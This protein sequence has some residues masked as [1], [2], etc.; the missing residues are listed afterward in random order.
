MV[1][2]SDDTAMTSPVSTRANAAASHGQR[3]APASASPYLADPAMFHDACG[4][5]FIA[6]ID[7]V[8]SHRVVDL[9]VH[10]VSALTHRGAVNADPLTGDG[11][12]VTIQIPFELLREDCER[13][14]TPVESGDDLAVAMVFLPHD[15]AKRPAAREELEQEVRATGVDAIGWRNVPH[16]PAQLGPQAL[17]SLPGIEQLL[18]RRPHDQQGPAFERSLYLARRRAERRFREQELDCYVVSMSARTVVYKGLMIAPRLADFYPDLADERTVSALALF[19]Q[20]FATNTLPSW[21]LA[22]PF[23]MTAHNGEFNTLLGNRTWMA[24]REPELASPVWGD[25]ID[26]LKPVIQPI[27]SDTASFDEAI[28]LLAMSGRDLLHATMMMIPQAWEN[29]P[30]L[31]PQLRAFYEYHACLSE[32]WDG[33]AAVALTNGVQV[34]AIMDRNGLRPA[35]YQVTR[36]GLVV[37]GSEVG[38]IEFEP[39]EVIESGRIGPGEMIA[40]DTSRRV[41]LHNDEIKT[42]IAGRRPYGDWVRRNLLHLNTDDRNGSN[43]HRS[44]EL[45]H[46]LLTLQQLHG[47]THEEIEY[48]VKPMAEDGKEPVGSMGDDTPLSALQDEPRLLYTYFKQK[49]AQVT[50]PA[51]DSVREEIVMSLDTYLGRRR[52]MLESTPEAARLLHLT[53][54]LIHDDELTA[55]RRMQNDDIKVSTLHARFK[56]DEGPTALEQALDDLCTA[57][58]MAA[59]EGYSVIVISDRL[60]D[61][62]WAPVPML[63]A[64]STVHHHLVR[65][66]R[67]MKTSLVA[68]TG[69]AR[70][71]HHFA[72]LIGFGASAVNPYLAFATLSG[73]HAEGEFDDKPLEHVMESYARA[74]DT[75]ILKIMSKMGISAVSSYHGAQIFEALGIGPEVVDRC[76]TGTTSRIGGIGFEEM[77]SDVYERH[78]LSFPETEK[79]AHGGWYK[80]RRD[81][82]YH[83]YSPAMW[84]AL[85]KVAQTGHAVAN[86]AGDEAYREYL[87]VLE[88]A[89]VGTLRDLLRLKSDRDPID[90]SEVEPVEQI[91]ARFVT[92]AMS[93]GA[94]S[95][96]AHED[97]AR[98]MNVL[99]GRSN[100]GEGGEDPRRYSPD[101]DKRDANSKIKQVASGRFGVTPAYLAAAQEFEIKISQGSKP[102][103]GGQ[104]PGIKVNPYIAQLRHVMPGTPLIS[105]PPHHDIYS[106]EDIAQLIYDLK[107]VNPRAKVCVKLV[108]SEG[109]GVIAAGVA[110][111][112]ADIIQISGAEGGTGASPLSSIKYAGS[113]WEI[114]LAE[115]QQALVMNS[116]RGRVT[117]RA[118]GGYRSGRDVIVAAMLGAEQYGF[119]TAA[120]IAVGC[121]MARQCH[122]NTCPVG[123]A[124]QREDLREKYF[125]TPEMLITFLTHVAKQVRQTLADLG[126]RSIEE[127]IGRADL[128]E[129]VEPE[130]AHRWHRIDLSRVIAPVDPEGREPHRSMQPRN[131]RGDWKRLDDEILKE[132]LDNIDSR[133]QVS[134]S[135]PVKNTNRAVGTRVAG[136]IAERYGDTGLPYGTIDLTFTGSAG[137]SFGAFLSRGMRLHLSGEANDYV[138]KGM[139][140]GEITIR[141]HPEAGFKGNGGVLVGNTVLYGATGGNLFVAGAAGERFAVRNSGARA[142]VE[143]IGDHGCEYMTDGV[144]VILGDTGRNFGAGMSNGVAFVLDERGDFRSRVNQEL[145]GL[146]QVTN[147]EDIELLEALIRRH[148][149]VTDSPRAREI[150]RN[151]RLMLP[152]FWK[153]APKFAITEDGAQT[154]V[155]RHLNML[156]RFRPTAAR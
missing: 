8:R 86:G 43:G 119:G 34:A 92:G 127:V 116:L 111:A 66:G 9:A 118:D 69:D 136:A 140:G 4:T 133:K 45:E 57:A 51:I 112:Y 90:I 22:Q 113:P 70:D 123:V 26:D 68:E 138:G 2:T 21:P 148:E 106:I 52:S 25:A 62:E 125:G 75:G 18:M 95:P 47:Y 53:S 131:D 156:Q 105:P 108:S 122:L 147:P 146:E 79:L 11:S 12:G 13:L 144:V 115:T 100:T 77:A 55:L 154:V 89:P 121:K 6:Q 64:V 49:F 132:V 67:R 31:D 98:A 93:L 80:Y 107:T 20:R 30:N 78:Q 65:T 36:D 40:V 58:V 102:G 71:V 32:P 129:Q 41:F 150:L 128:L 81:G 16:D 17:E 155:R 28:E 59:D 24:A 74:V 73:L 10:A 7:G 76:F 117:L 153:V 149:E 50:N 96:E 83:A 99:G 152:K 104:L 94:L 23:R 44:S 114:G 14:G 35:R 27:G 3:S 137:Q 139:G 142:V 61:R 19:H 124:T 130:A 63:L 145:V 1:A 134:L 15:E 135:Y 56:V 46:D 126:Y 87:D 143:G 85:H 5:G 151:W 120:M 60:V 33:P 29:M 72:A 97:I 141:S 84:R 38:L 101:G 42:E 109:V 91:T 48:V 110:K 82:E 103:E 39:S 37:M 88:D 54:P